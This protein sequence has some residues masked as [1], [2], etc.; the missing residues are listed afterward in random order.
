MRLFPEPGTRFLRVFVWRTKK[1]MRAYWRADGGGPFNGGS[2][3]ERLAYCTEVERTTVSGRRDPC[4]AEVH[5][6]ARRLGT[7]IVAHEMFH[8]TTAWGRRIGFPW[9]RLGADDSVT[10]EE[11]RLA[12]AHNVLCGE[13]VERAYAAGLYR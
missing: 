13:F 2:W 12:Y 3:G 11:E 1:D 7:S 8:A 4:F 10:Q 6:T 5:F 9:K